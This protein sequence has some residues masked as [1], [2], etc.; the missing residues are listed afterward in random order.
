MSGSYVIC[1]DFN[2]PDIR[3][4]T[5]CSGSKGRKFLET[6][7]DKFMMQHVEMATHNSGNILDLILS[8]EDDLVRDVEMCG[9]I[10]K[11]D[12]ALIKFKVHIDATRSKSTKMGRNF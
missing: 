3:W 12:H 11:S 8:N 9:K 5:G 1:G 10:G 7:H 2:F 4:L 6:V